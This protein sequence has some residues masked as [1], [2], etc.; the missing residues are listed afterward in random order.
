MKQSN[1]Q[2]LREVVQSWMRE[3]GVDAK[4]LESRIIIHWEEWM[5]P[6]INKYTEKVWVNKNQLYVKVSSAALRQELLFSREQIKKNVNEK[7][8]TAFIKNVII[9]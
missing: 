5:G 6:T 3:N 2:S 1:E 9:F 7:L 8:E 4:L